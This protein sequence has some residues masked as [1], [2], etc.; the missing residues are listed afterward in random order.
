M[1]KKKYALTFSEVSFPIVDPVTKFGG[2]PVWLTEP[3]W[4][5][6]RMYNAPMQFIGQIRLYPELFGPLEAQMAYLFMTQ[7]EGES[8]FPETWD[9]EAGENA[10]I[11]QPG[12]WT[13]PTLPLTEG[14][15]LRKWVKEPTP[16]PAEGPSWW[17]WLQGKR[18][19]RWRHSRWQKVSC[20]YAVELHAGEDPDEP[21]SPW[22]DPDDKAAWDTRWT[23]FSEDKIGG[24][25][26]PTINLDRDPFPY[27]YGGPWHLLLQLNSNEDRYDVNFGTDGSGYVLLSEDG[28]VGKLLWSR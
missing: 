19:W 20:E 2:Q 7:Y 8:V 10:V 6:S 17:K 27:P 11:L 3:Q 15:H 13:G 14:P 5:L 28:R 21:W 9:P 1:P 23:L 26:V 24:I 12:T 16:P 4:P 25:P 22:P 18:R